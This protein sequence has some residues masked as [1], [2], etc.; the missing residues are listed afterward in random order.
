MKISTSLYFDRSTDQ[1]GKVQASMSKTQEQLSTGLQVVKPSDAP[2]KASLVTRLE[3]NL[4]RQTSYQDT[5]K[6]INVRK[7]A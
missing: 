4:A 2:D 7:T 6:A 1:L 5:I 3:T